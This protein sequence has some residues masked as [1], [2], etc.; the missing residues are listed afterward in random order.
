MSSTADDVLDVAE[1]WV[2]IAFSTFN[3]YATAWFTAMGWLESIMWWWALTW[4]WEKM[5]WIWSIINEL[6]WLSKFRDSLSEEN[7]ARF[8]QFVANSAMWLMLWVKN[9]SNIYKNPKK[10][11]IEN[12]WLV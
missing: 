3:P 7:Q 4:F 5:W 8:D 1:W 6:P 2:D 9:K 12:L 11:L 10:F